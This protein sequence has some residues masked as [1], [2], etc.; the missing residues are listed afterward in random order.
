[1]KRLL[2]RISLVGAIAASGLLSAQDKPEWQNHKII[3]INKEKPHATFGVFKD[4]AK[5]LSNQRDQSQYYKGLN[6]TWKF[7]WVKSA[8]D[9]PRNFFKPGKDVSKW[10]DIEVPSN[11]QMKGFG[12]PIYLNQPLAFPNN[13]PFIPDEYS[14]VGSY[15]RTFTIPEHWNHRE[16]FIHFDG[17]KSAFYI[18]LNGKKVGYSQG[19]MTPA[20][21]N[22]TP[23]LKAGEN[24][25]A[26]E[27]YRWSDGSYLEDQDSW[28]LSGI[29]RDVY[30][31]SKPDVH[32]RDIHA[33]TRLD[34]QYKDAQLD[35]KIDIRNQSSEMT[36]S[37]YEV[38]CELFDAN[39]KPIKGLK[40]SVTIPKIN[41]GKEHR[42]SVSIAVVNPLK[43]TAETPNLYKL[44]V[45]LRRNGEIEEVTRINIGFK[46]VEVVG[47]QFLVNGKAIYL[48]GVN[49]LEIDPYRGNAV[50]KERMVED[51][52]LM[53]QFNIN[54]VR[55]SH[56]PSHPYFMDLCDQYG[57][58]VYDE[59]NLETHENRGPRG[60]YGCGLG[61]LPGN[62]PIWGDQCVD[63]M[64]RLLHR[65]KNRASVVIWSLGNESGA[66][67]AFIRMRDAA[68]RIAPDRPVIYHDMRYHP[69]P[70]TGGFAMDIQDAGYVEADQL[71]MAYA[72]AETFQKTQWRRYISYED[73]IARP[74]IFNEYAHAMG[75]SLGNF[76]EIWKVVEKYPSLQGGFIWD[77]ADQ[78]IINRTKNG[79]SY[80]AY[81]GDFGPVTI[82]SKKYKKYVGNFLVNGLVLPDRKP[83]PALW[84]VKKVQQNI[85][86]SAVDSATGKFNIKNK[87]FF[88]N[89]DFV[90]ASWQLLEDGYPVGNG[91]LNPPTI[92]PLKNADVHISLEGYVMAKE[93][94]YF[95]KI[96][97]RLKE[98]TLWADKGH[99]VAWEQFKLSPRQKQVATNNTDNFAKMQKTTDAFVI[100]A[101]DVVVKINRKNGFISSY[102]VKGKELLEGE[103]KPNFWRAL[104]DND[105]RIRKGFWGQWRKATDNI[106]LVSLI[107]AGVI[108]STLVFNAK[109]KLPD[110]KSQYSISYSIS[111]DGSVDVSWNL[112]TTNPK[113]D[114]VIPR[115]GISLKIEKSLQQVKWYGRGPH[116]SY[117]DRKVSA[118]FGIFKKSVKEL[119]HNY[120]TAQ[121]NGS[122]S[123]VRWVKFTGVNG[124]GF[125]ILGSPEFCFNAW[126]YSQADLDKAKHDYELPER[127]FVTV[128]IDYK[129]TGLGGTNS[130][131]GKPLERYRLKPGKHSSTFTIKP[132]LIK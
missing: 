73:F 45:S 58:Y 111:G 102:C 131:G 104:T 116:E 40:S 51:I 91:V 106:Q 96:S 50:T 85:E 117:W 77:W 67:E 36:T 62:D 31:Y 65:D 101:G 1:M 118:Q 56:Y 25:L 42:K 15:R 29:Y 32:I 68:R 10:T 127:D 19:S 109:M 110:T 74:N 75:N 89:L 69:D 60:P 84:E 61:D 107:N 93:K 13:P 123:D 119:H 6:G 9:R 126:N 121:E 20:E 115:I 86:I 53:K 132:I 97:F 87:Y 71:E 18:W 129:Q 78:A 52:R 11:W 55:T 26:V 79:Q 124:V 88:K 66:G 112:K 94:E 64:E 14:P 35:V 12:T 54:A 17:V 5:A 57:M 4:V 128:N 34:D 47:N 130:W 2:Q 76:A 59:A 41:H 23:Y 37:D 3:G 105:T 46:R 95:V 98:N 82:H 8:N 92:E 70:K 108:D 39:D 22:L 63:R 33:V 27:V 30:L 81:G 100:S 103:L 90:E 48:K 43:W 24:T 125:E 99:E 113:K 28:D 114:E 49:R 80:F 16:T 44:I 38:V 21:F 122:R 120:V 83:S 7:H 72:S